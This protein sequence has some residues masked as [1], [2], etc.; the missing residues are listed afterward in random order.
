MTVLETLY[1]AK[2]RLENNRLAFFFED[3]KTCTCGHIYAAT[4]G[5]KAVDDFRVTEPTGA[6]L[7]AL[8]TIVSA[9][10]GGGAGY[11]AHPDD[12]VWAVSDYTEQ[13]AEDDDCVEREHALQVINEAI[14]VIEAQQ[15]ADRLNVLAQAAAVV[16]AVPVDEQ[17]VA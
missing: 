8:Q 11:T 7:E 14:V 2:A 15:E 3:W 17:V 10:P 6:Y 5:R 9:L 16:D 13:L 4:T 12:L 1:A